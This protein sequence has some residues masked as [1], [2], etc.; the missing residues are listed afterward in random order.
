MCNMCQKYFWVIIR[1]HFF[2]T[3]Y[4]FRRWCSATPQITIL[5]WKKRCIAVSHTDFPRHISVA[6]GCSFTQKS[7][8]SFPSPHWLSQKPLN[9]SCTFCR[10]CEPPSFTTTNLPLLGPEPTTSYQS[11]IGRL[12]LTGVHYSSLGP[13]YMWISNAESNTY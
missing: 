5:N 6:L 13:H 11:F 1:Q 10:A 8:L 3:P 12:A 9:L 4:V 2:R 7:S